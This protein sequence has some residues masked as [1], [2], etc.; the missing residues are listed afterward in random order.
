MPFGKIN[1]H[2]FSL[3]SSLGQTTPMLRSVALCRGSISKWANRTTAPRVTPKRPISLGSSRPFLTRFS[4]IQQ[5]PLHQ[6]GFRSC[7]SHTPP[8]DFDDMPPLMADDDEPQLDYNEPPSELDSVIPSL[9]EA[10]APL[11]RNDNSTQQTLSSAKPAYQGQRNRPM[12]PHKPQH[13]NGN[14]S[15]TF[16]SSY[17]KIDENV[18]ISY[19]NRKNITFKQNGN[20]QILIRDC[21][22]CHD[23]KSHPTNLWKLY[24]YME[25]GN[26][27]CF[28]C[29]SQGSWYVMI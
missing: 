22:F 18:L 7:S 17:Y 29:S 4:T 28:R 20:R 13:L 10:S 16:V 19:L 5:S 25:N 11:L 12:A 24:I 15:G 27:F 9:G 1:P 21:P 26:Y 3:Q 23:T 8:P 14:S 2:L 6:F